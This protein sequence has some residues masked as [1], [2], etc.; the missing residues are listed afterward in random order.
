[1][2]TDQS[3]PGTEDLQWELSPADAPYGIL[4]LYLPVVFLGG[5]LGMLALVG[6]AFLPAITADLRLVGL[7][8][9]L[10]LVGG[11]FS[12][13]YLWPVIRDPDQRPSFDGVDWLAHLHPAGVVVASVIGTVLVVGGSRLVGSWTRLVLFAVLVLVPLPLLALVVEEGHLDRRTGEIDLQ[14][15]TVDVEEVAGVRSLRFDSVTV[16]WLSYAD[17]VSRW[18][19]PSLLVVPDTVAEEVLAA[20]TAGVDGDA[21]RS[22]RDPDPV[23]R[24]VLA[25]IAIL[26]LGSA[27]GAAVFLDGPVRGM[28]VGLTGVLGGL[29]AAAAYYVA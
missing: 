6:V 17:G 25:G 4:L 9:L 12:L 26:C 24:V 14:Y 19:S 2:V 20:L 10:V 27:V 11:P 15:R 21:E 29:F 23:A 8:V 3:A 1:M 22:P 13:L 18:G 28:L 16:C 7:V 5:H